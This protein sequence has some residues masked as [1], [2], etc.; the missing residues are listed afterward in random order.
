MSI[1]CGSRWLL[2]ERSG[3]VYEIWTPSRMRGTSVYIS[4]SNREWRLGYTQFVTEVILKVVSVTS[5]ADHIHPRKE[6]QMMNISY[7]G[8]ETEQGLS[9]G[10]MSVLYVCVCVCAR[11]HSIQINVPPF[12]FKYLVF[13]KHH[14]VETCRC[15]RKALIR[16]TVSDLTNPRSHTATYT[17]AEC[18]VEGAFIILFS[19]FHL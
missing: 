2:R 1:V 15:A 4:S 12:L 16:L 5:S 11:A 6:T 17:E 9:D 13:G 7:T 8:P 14:A 18:L 19:Y 10:A 3:T